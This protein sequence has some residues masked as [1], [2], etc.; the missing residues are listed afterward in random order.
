MAG[1]GGRGEVNNGGGVLGSWQPHKQVHSFELLAVWSFQQFGSCRVLR[2]HNLICNQPSW[3]QHQGGLAF[4]VVA[5]GAL[6]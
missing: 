5:Q 1:G 6:A 4:K 2:T 3:S